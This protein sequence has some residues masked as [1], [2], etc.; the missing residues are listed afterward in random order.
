MKMRLSSFSRVAIRRC[1]GGFGLIHLAITQES[2]DFAVRLRDKF[3]IF[4]VA[5]KARIDRW[6]SDRPET[7]RNRGELP[8]IRHQPGMRIR[9]KTRMIPQ[10]MAEIQQMLLTQSA[11]EE[12]ARVNTRR[13]MPLEVNHVTGLI[14]IAAAEKMI[15]A[16]FADRRQRRISRYVAA[17]I[18]VVFVG[19][20]HHGG[21]IPTNQAFDAPLQN[22][23][24]GIWHFLDAPGWY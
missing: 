6:R 19:P 11:F 8:E 18:R 20:N 9:R 10:L 5:K 13:G 14:S 24:A 23:I 15:E 3:A 17:D 21:G 7:H 4:Q 2:I 22:S 16:N 1:A 12:R